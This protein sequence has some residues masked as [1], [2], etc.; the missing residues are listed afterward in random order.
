[1]VNEKETE[2]GFADRKPKKLSEE[3]IEK[4]IEERRRSVARRKEKREEKRIEKL[5]KIELIEAE[6]VVTK[7]P[8][9]ETG[10]AFSGEGGFVTTDIR[11]KGKEDMSPALEDSAGVCYDEE[12]DVKIDLRDDGK[13]IGASVNGTELNL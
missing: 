12:K 1:M 11:R 5:E 7:K 2:K 9:I 3:D 13:F 10:G 8:K 4:I 6:E